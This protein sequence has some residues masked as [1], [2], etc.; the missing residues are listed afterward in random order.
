MAL[1]VVVAVTVC[2]VA[3]AALECSREFCKLLPAARGGPRDQL[4]FAPAMLALYLSV[5]SPS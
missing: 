1:H 4:E 3:G 5:Q 2:R